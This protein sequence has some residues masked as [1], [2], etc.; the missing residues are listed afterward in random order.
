[1]PTL[2]VIVG[3]TGVGK[4]ALGVELSGRLGG[5]PIISADSRQVYDGIPICSAAPSGDQLCRT[6]HYF[7]GHLPLTEHY[8]ASRFE[9]DVLDLLPKLFERNDVVMMVGGSML[10]IDAVCRGMDDIPAVPVELRS[11]LEV[12][13]REHGIAPIADELKRL[14]PVYYDQVDLQNHR[15]VIHALEICLASGERYSSLR[16]NSP[17]ARPFGVLKVGLRLDRAM[18]YER[19]N[20]RVDGMMSSGLLEEARAVY[21]LRHLNS[22]NILG[23]RELFRYLSGEWTLDFAVEKIKQHT[24]NYSRR[25]MTWFRRDTDIEWFSPDDSDGIL[26]YIGERL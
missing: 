10:Y 22:L 2:L 12:R 6:K 18:L 21:P 9:R 7:V 23:H 11:E 17:D 3:P 26:N 5:L 19:I 14:D 15:R 16:R 4:T 24:R 13:Y 25:Q 8:S 1:M 20:R